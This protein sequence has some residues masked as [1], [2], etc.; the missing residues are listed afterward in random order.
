MLQVMNNSFLSITTLLQYRLLYS[1]S[2]QPTARSLTGP[3]SSP[4]LH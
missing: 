2:L 3:E 1:R 4:K